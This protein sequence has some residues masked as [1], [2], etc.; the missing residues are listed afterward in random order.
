[1][2]EA[3]APVHV[4]KILSKAQAGAAAGWGWRDGAQLAQLCARPAFCHRI[5]CL[6]GK[7]RKSNHM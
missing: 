6:T 5:Q 7:M 3:M 1:M 2:E 4:V